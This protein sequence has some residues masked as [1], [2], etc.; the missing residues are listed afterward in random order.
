MNLLELI[1]KRKQ[2]SEKLQTLTTTAK[3]IEKRKFTEE[4]EVQ[5]NELET[6]MK[7]IDIE[8]EK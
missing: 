4:E 8:I 3:T 5:F 2:A 6:E 1:D 7:D